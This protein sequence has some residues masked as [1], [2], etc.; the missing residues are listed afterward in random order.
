MGRSFLVLDIETIPD[1]AYARPV[2][3]PAPTRPPVAPVRLGYLTIDA[4]PSGL[5]VVDGQEVGDTPVFKLELTIGAHEI[6]IRRE[7]YRTYSEQIEISAG[8]EARKRITM[9]PEGS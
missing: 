2:Q 5:L 9:V 6:E 1:S 7:G 8:N 3:R 4:T